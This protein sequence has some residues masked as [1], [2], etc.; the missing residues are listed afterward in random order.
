MFDCIV[1]A[2]NP[3]ATARTLACLVEGVV[4]GVIARATIAVETPSEELDRI[5]DVSGCDVAQGFA[6]L[7]SQAHTP[8]ALVFADGALPAPG[9]P[10]RLMAEI[11]RKGLPERDVAWW[12]RPEAA[13]ENLRLRLALGTGRSASLG[14][15]ALLP[16][17]RLV[18]SAGG[19][20][21]KAKGGDRIANVPGGRLSA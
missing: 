7:A 1:I 2:R 17:G 4:A 20:R 3:D 11:A 14:C 18:A 13:L 21:V 12:F 19:G 9:W 6:N 15:G 10:K 5:A 16:R 8:H